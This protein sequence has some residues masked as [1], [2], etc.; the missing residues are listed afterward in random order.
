MAFTLLILLCA[1]PVKEN[2]C[3]RFRNGNFVFHHIGRPSDDYVVQRKDSIQTEIDKSTGKYVKLSVKWI[4]D[5]NY[6]VNLIETTIDIPDSIQKQTKL[7]PLKT[8]IIS[9]SDDYYVFRSGWNNKNFVTDT[10][11]IAK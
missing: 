3:K 1:I 10:L 7:I 6:E 4:D 8:E 2:G 11:W 9:T 5:C